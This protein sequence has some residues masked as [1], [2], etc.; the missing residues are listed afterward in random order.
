[1]D[2][3]SIL[4]KEKIFG[5]SSRKYAMIAMTVAS[6]AIS[7]SGLIIRSIETTN[8]W[9]INFYRIIPF[10]AVIAIFFLV[11]YRSASVRQLRKTELSSLWAALFLAVTGIS[12]IEAFTHTTIANATLTLSATPFI[13][14]VI[15][16]VALGE[17]SSR[18]SWAAMTMAFFGLSVMVSGGVGTGNLYGNFMALLAAFN[19]ALF[20]VIVR[21]YRQQELLP[22]LFLAGILVM[23]ASVIMS[24]HDLSISRSDLILCVFWG[25]GLSGFGHWVFVLAASKLVAAELTLFSLF[26]SALAPIWVWIVFAENPGLLVF[27]GGGI[28]IASV[29]IRA[30]MELSERS[31]E[32]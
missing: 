6:I 30:M 23:L 5:F 7:F 26:E 13:T 19:F 14:M 28:V 27:F 3:N 31:P 18:V 15:A 20:A 32:N 29:L 8:I 17:R 12:I 10:T 4:K 1:M 2:T 11:R 9:Q 24:W 25:A 22:A 16:F 21:V